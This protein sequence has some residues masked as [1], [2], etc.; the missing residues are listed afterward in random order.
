MVLYR[1]SLAEMFV[2]YMDSDPNWSFRTYLD[3][4]E[5]GFGALSSPLRAGH[6]LPGGRRLSSMRCCPDERGEPL[7]GKSVICLFERDTGAPLWRHAETVNGAYAGQPATELVMRTIPSVGNYDYIV[8]WV[9]TEAGTIRIDVGATGIDAVKGVAARSM[10]DPGAAAD[11]AT[12]NLVAPG[13]VGV[14]HDHFLSFRLDVD[15]DGPGNT[16]VR[17]RLVRRRRREQT[18]AAA[19][20]GP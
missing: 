4:G 14:N 12:G 2:P 18:A 7:A 17:E 13:A 19:C 8:D 16:L 5:Y 1:G 3:V 10:Q 11:T 20:G 15:I 6:R 9:L